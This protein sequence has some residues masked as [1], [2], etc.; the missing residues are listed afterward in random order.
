MRGS[1]SLMLLRGECVERVSRSM[2]GWRGVGIVSLR[3]GRGKVRGYW[4][5]GECVWRVVRVFQGR[6]P[7]HWFSL[8]V[9]LLQFFCSELADQSVLFLCMSCKLGDFCLLCFCFLLSCSAFFF[10][11][12]ELCQEFCDDRI[13]CDAYSLMFKLTVCHSLTA[14][15]CRCFVCCRCCCW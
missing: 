1:H 12:T 7:L 14:V 4:P 8:L 5:Q 15:S 13:A 11:G 10:K 6:W 9:L 3:C 2:E